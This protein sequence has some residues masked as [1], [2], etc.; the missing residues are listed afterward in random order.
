MRPRIVVA[1]DDEEMR[2]RIVATLQKDGYDV[3]QVA[4]G[5]RLLIHVIAL[6][7]DPSELVR[8]EELERRYIVRVM[9]ALGGNKT[10]AARILGLDRKRLYRMLDRLGIGSSKNA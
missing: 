3:A 7:D 10:A 5:M 6:N 4:D 1:E 9:E 2:R 8:M